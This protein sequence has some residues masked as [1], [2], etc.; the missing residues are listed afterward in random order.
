M[1]EPFLFLARKRNASAKKKCCSLRSPNGSKGRSPPLISFALCA[2]KKKLCNFPIDFVYCR[3]NRYSEFLFYLTHQNSCSSANIGRANVVCRVRWANIWTR[4]V[5]YI[6][7]LCIWPHIIY[8]FTYNRCLNHFFFLLE[9]E[10]LHLWPHLQGVCNI[11]LLVL[12]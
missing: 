4:S 8:Y 10:T 5:H 1:F 9:K 11:K 6:T 12:P 7:L 3:E 2:Q